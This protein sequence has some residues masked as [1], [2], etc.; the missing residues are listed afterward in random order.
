MKEVEKK[1]IC[2]AKVIYVCCNLIAE[3]YPLDKFEILFILLLKFIVKCINIIKG[4]RIL[5]LTLI[6]IYN[7]TR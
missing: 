6:M 3:N 5:I 4:M 2:N 1:D 7:N